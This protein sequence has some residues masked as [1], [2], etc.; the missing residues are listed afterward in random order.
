M[1]F[2]NPFG[3]NTADP[4]SG[5]AHMN[6]AATKSDS[7]AD[8]KADTPTWLVYKKEVVEEERRIDFAVSP[9]RKSLTKGRKRG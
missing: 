1:P 4:F 7:S 9:M 8:S 6:D 3:Y 2:D 5:T